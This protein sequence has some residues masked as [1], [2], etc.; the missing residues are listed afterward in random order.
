MQLRP[1]LEPL[2]LD[3][4]LVERLTLLAENLDTER[5]STQIEEWLAK[6]NATASTNL[7]W[8]NFRGIYGYQ[9]H[10]E[11]VKSVLL[12]QRVVAVPDISREELGEIVRRIQENPGGE[13][14]TDFYLALLQANVPYRGVSGLIFW[15]NLYFGDED[16]SRTL[17]PEQIVEIALNNPGN[18]STAIAL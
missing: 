15:P 6:F 9:N 17:T 8:Q 10:D 4:K 14:E 7:E 13:S 12:R 1:Q 5:H 2:S 18:P 11:W 3:E 16:V